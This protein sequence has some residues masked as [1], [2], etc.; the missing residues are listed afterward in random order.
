VDEP[1]RRLGGVGTRKL[2]DND[3]VTIWEMVLA[4]GERSPVHRHDHDYVLVQL[5]GDRIAVEPEPDSQGPHRSYMEAPVVE[6][7]AFFVRKG[8][9]ETALNVGSSEYREVLIE[10]KD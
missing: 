7:G 3:R 6:G 9:V 2:L 10:L 1:G 4:P 8:G 5:K